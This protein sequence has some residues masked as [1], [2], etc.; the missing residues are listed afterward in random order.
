MADQVGPST[1]TLNKLLAIKKEPFRYGFFNV[2]RL[3]D[4]IFRQKART[5]DSDRPQDDAIRI[6]QNPSLIFAPSTIASFELRASDAT[7]HLHTYFLGIFGPNGPLPSHITDFAQLR[8]KHHRDETFARFADVFHHRMASFFYRA[9][10]ESQPTVHMDRPESD[11][12]SHYVA[13]LSGFGL[14]SLHNRDA[15]PDNARRFF[16][17]HLA[18]TTRH[19]SGLVSILQAFYKVPVEIIPFV[20]HWVHLPEDCHWKLG[21]MLQSNE[22]GVS[23]TLGARIRDCQQRFQ[24]VLG[25][26]GYETFCKLLP[27]G[28][29]M[30]RLR[31]IVDQYIGQEFS[32]HVQLVLKKEEVPRMTLGRQGEL[33]WSTWLI[34]RTPARDSDQLVIDPLVAIQKTKLR[35]ERSS[36]ATTVA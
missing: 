6:G 35:R 17:A 5:G 10:A 13:A 2:V 8:I 29:S 1:D 36:R 25:P 19:S 15:M 12:F 21:R 11:R 31:A 22:L 18:C 32:W 28:S 16:A 14:P 26:L 9:W 30:T 27:Y 4:C 3:L 24:I 20:S 23:I 33:G 34:S 7:W